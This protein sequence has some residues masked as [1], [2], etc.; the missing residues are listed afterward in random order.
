VTTDPFIGGGQV[1]GF[2][3]WNSGEGIRSVLINGQLVVVNKLT[4]FANAQVV[5]N[6]NLL[7]NEPEGIIMADSA[8]GPVL[9]RVWEN[10][11]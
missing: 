1:H 8:G 10:Y 6:P 11:N 2:S 9:Q 7:N 4:D 3:F 5:F